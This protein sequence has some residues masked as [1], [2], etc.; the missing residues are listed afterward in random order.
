[1][2]EA[3]IKD[4]DFAFEFLDSRGRDGDAIAVLQVRHVG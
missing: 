1:M 4:E 3:V 2:L